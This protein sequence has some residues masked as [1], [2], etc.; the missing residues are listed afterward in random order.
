VALFILTI[1]TEVPTAIHIVGSTTV[2]VL[3]LHPISQYM[4]NVV[5]TPLALNI[6]KAIVLFKQSQTCAN[7]KPALPDWFSCI[8]KFEDVGGARLDTSPYPD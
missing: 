5:P 3:V 7:P 1:N 4:V 2:D 8:R 6:N